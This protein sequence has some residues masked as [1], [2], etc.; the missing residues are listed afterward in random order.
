[1]K[2]Y[3]N[4]YKRTGLAKVHVVRTTPVNR[5]RSMW[6]HDPKQAWCG[7]FATSTPASPKVTVDPAKPLDEGLTWC[8]ACLGRA[9]EYAGVLAQVA[10]LLVRGEAPDA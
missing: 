3:Y 7:V 6:T 2:A 5:H 9:A 8:G 1:M 10:A 4:G